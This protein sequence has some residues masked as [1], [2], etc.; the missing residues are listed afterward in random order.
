MIDLYKKESPKAKEKPVTIAIKVS[1]SLRDAFNE[2]CAE[3]DIEVAKVLR[4]FIMR[5]LDEAGKSYKE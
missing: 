4:R 2:L 3:R 5:E 1:P